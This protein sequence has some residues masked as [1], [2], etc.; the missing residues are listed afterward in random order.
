MHR[1][2]V[3]AVLRALAIGALAGILAWLG[4]PYTHGADFAQFHFH[5]RNWLAGR[6]PY[7][8]G[9]PI[10]R[11]TRVVPEPFFYPFPTLFVL[12][13]FALVPLRAGYALFVGASTAL[14]SWAILLKS[15]QRLPMLLGSSFILA[16]GLGQWTPLVTTTLLIP[17]LGWLAVMKP[18]VGLA[19]V[20]ADPSPIR[21]LGGG[22]LLLLSLAFQ[23]NWPAEWL[24]NLRSM[25]GHPIPLLIPGG[26]LALLALLRWRRP[27]AR[28]LIGMACV[29]QL[30]YF[31][32]QL[33][34]F[35]CAKTRRE[36][37]ILSA[38]SLVAWVIALQAFNREGQPAFES[39]ALVLLGV[40]LPALVFVLRR[41][42][43]GNVPGFVERGV[44]AW[45]SWLRGRSESG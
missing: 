40:Y 44:A 4:F 21:I 22:V 14:L 15:P 34:L 11:R 33:P 42:N 38:T 45:P 8:G 32:D 39:D 35:L 24:R 28:L 23:P 26:V 3:K 1:P 36:S 16:A 27:E 10:M 20:V 5:A 25:P 19:S 30:M 43:V 9:F 37:I 41:E 17:I 7:A 13:P 18:N 12:A 2:S 31:A 29:P 6:D